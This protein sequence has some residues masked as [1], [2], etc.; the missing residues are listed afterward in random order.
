[1]FKSAFNPQKLLSKAQKNRN[2]LDKLKKEGKYDDYKKNKAA[3]LKERR[4]KKK[5]I[6]SAIPIEMRS[7]TIVKKREANREYMRKYRERLKIKSNPNNIPDVTL[8]VARNLNDITAKSYSC[9]Q[10]LG[11]AV[12]KATRAFPTSPT[13]KKAVLAK[14]F[15]DLDDNH[16][17]ELVN[18]ILPPRHRK[19]LKN[20][21]GLID[22][23]QLFYN[24]DDVTWTSPKSKDIKEYT[25]PDGSKSLLPT[26]HMTLT[27]K[28]AHALFNDERRD[29]NK[30]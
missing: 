9:A 6:E 5:E 21:E 19:S 1:M 24:R 26:K 25:L 8:D 10:T 13:K 18:A 11:K 3:K 28:E 12:R 23:I 7:D 30:G 14:M 15:N 20:K 22:D 17:S 2:Y 4:E 29:E 27:V 16:R